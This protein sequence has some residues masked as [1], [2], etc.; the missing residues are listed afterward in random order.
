MRIL[1]VTLLCA[2]L[3]ACANNPLLKAD[4]GFPD[5]DEKIAADTVNQLARLY[6]PARTQINFIP[7]APMSFGALLAGK[8]RARGYAVSETRAAAAS[9]MAKI[10]PSEV[11]GSVFAPK[12]ATANIP[13][14][15]LPNN[16]GIDLRYMLDHSR[17]GDFSRITLQ[18]GNSLLARAYLPD[19]GVMAPAGAWTYK[20]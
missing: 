12:P 7:S 17:T 14:Q 8:L 20:E 2:S 16:L 18:V 10:L 9:R 1:L 6:P 5:Y 15:S 19:N 3:A 11:F 4:R 13:A